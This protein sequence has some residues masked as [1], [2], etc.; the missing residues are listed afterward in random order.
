MRTLYKWTALALGLFLQLNAVGQATNKAP[1]V[2]EG[3]GPY[4]QLIIRGATLINSTLSPPIGPVDIV[5]EKNR[6]VSITTVG[7]TTLPIDPKRRPALKA[8][9]K[10]LQA[11]GMYLMP[12]FIDTHAHIGGGSKGA[13]AEYVFKL[14]MAH[15]VTTIAEPGSM[16][17]LEWTLD[18]KE[19][20]SKNLIT[21][22]RIKAYSRF[23]LGSNDPISTPEQ[24]RQWVRN[25]AKAGSDGIKFFGAAPDIMTAAL[26][27]NKKLGLRSMMHHSQTDVG[28]W[29]VMNSA[30][31]GL[32]S[33]E[34]WYGLPEALFTDRTVQNY[35]LDYNYTNEQDRFGEAG[36]LWKQAAPPFSDR[37][38]KV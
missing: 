3:D 18:Q 25:N 12:G 10:E 6:I 26:D 15:G 24:A 34:H 38:N 9:G 7:N 14:W 19:K 5:V 28:R 32:N 27:E 23:G 13:H 11:E 30:R 33:M 8:G 21:A 29:N 31:A 2:K 1:E 35:S 36:T 22:P 37:W 20:S 17:G 4:N 16:N